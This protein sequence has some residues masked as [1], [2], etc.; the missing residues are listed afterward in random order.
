MLNLLVRIV[1]ST[2][3]VAALLGAASSVFVHVN[4]AR[5]QCT[6][7]CAQC[8]ASCCKAL[9]AACTSKAPKCGGS[10]GLPCNK[11][12]A[13]NMRTCLKPK[14]WPVTILWAVPFARQHTFFVAKAGLW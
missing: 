8:A 3:S 7:G 6:G 1:S 12:L 13:K 9:G 14:Q 2:A 10:G 5:Y 4:D 11:T